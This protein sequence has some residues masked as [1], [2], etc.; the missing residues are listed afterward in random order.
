M[1]AGRQTGAG[2]GRGTGSG[3]GAPSRHSAAAPGTPAAD[4]RRVHVGPEPITLREHE[5]RVAHDSA[6]AVV[7]FCGVVRDHDGG[8]GVV[9]LHYTAHPSAQE[10]LEAVA[11]TVAAGSA[12]AVRAIAV[13]HRVGDLEIGDEALV[14]AVAADHRAEAFAACAEL[15]EAVKEQI[16]VWKHQFFSDGT[17][18][19]VGCA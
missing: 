9:R 3:T 19:W 18:E 16:P 11:R 15:V 4:V 6:G 10:V 2:P 17:D 14:A 8:R 13:S 7:G 1:S 12:G 5:Q